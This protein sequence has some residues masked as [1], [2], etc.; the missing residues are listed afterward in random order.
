M[1]DE[2]EDEKVTNIQTGRAPQWYG[3]MGELL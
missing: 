1:S 3:K 2:Y